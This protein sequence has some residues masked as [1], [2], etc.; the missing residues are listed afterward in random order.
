MKLSVA[1]VPFI[2]SPTQA[3]SN[4]CHTLEI[5]LTSNAKCFAN[6]L[7]MQTMYENKHTS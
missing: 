5:M 7:E 4:V 6:A 3:L 1:S 2:H